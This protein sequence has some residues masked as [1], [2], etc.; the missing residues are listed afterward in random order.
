MNTKVIVYNGPN[1]DADSV[2]GSLAQVIKAATV[3][4]TTVH[5]LSVTAIEGGSVLVTI[6]WA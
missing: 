1:G 4:V 3:G 5:G 6:V 2:T